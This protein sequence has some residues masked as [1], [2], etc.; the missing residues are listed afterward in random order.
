MRT[1]QKKA[2]KSIND[3][4][5]LSDYVALAPEENQEEIKNLFDLYY[6][7]VYGNGTGLV[8]SEQEIQSS[9]ELCDRIRKLK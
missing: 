5:L 6:K 7:V 9:K 1:K 2:E 3:R 8:I 4:G